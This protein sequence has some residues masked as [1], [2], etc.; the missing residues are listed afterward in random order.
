M[1]ALNENNFPHVK[2]VWPY[3]SSQQHL[4]NQCNPGKP[5]LPPSCSL[6]FVKIKP[7]Y[8][9]TISSFQLPGKT[10]SIVVICTTSV[11]AQLCRVSSLLLRPHHDDRIPQNN[12][13]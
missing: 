3:I 10:S 6:V 13:K 8:H 11:P 7:T 2:I 1:T 4:I 12:S 5:Y 9:I